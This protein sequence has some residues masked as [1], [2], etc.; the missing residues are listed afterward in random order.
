VTGGTYVVNSAGDLGGNNVIVDNS[1]NLSAILQVNNAATLSNGITLN[2]GGAL[3]NSGTIGRGGPGV[4]GDIGNVINRTGGSITSTG[5]NG[6][7]FFLGGAITNNAGAA[8]SGTTGVYSDWPSSRTATVTNSGT[9][10]GTTGNGIDLENG[11]T[12]VNQAGGRISGV[13][14]GALLWGGSVLNTGSGSII[15]ASQAGSAG[16]SLQDSGMVTNTNGA[17]IAGYDGVQ[18]WNV[19][20]LINSGGASITGN[21]GNG[22]WS[23]GGPGTVLN[24]GTGS[25]IS[26]WWGVYLDSGG[27]VTNENGA[28]ITSTGNAAVYLSD[29]GTVINGAGSSIVGNVNAVYGIYGSGNSTTVR[30]AGSITGDVR[31]DDNW[32]NRVTLFTG[33]K[34]NGDLY[35]NTDHGST[36]T[37]DGSG[38]QLYSQAVSGL[39]TFVGGVLTKQGSG[40]WI[41][42]KDVNIFTPAISP[43]STIISAGTLEVD[44]TLP[45]TVT[46]QNGGTLAGT[47]KVRATTVQ[48]GGT[49]APGRDGIGTLNVNGSYRQN[50]GSVYTVQLDPASSAADRIAVTGSV[51]LS[52][53]A[54]LNISR[55]S[56]VPYLIGTR[57]TVLTATGNISGSYTLTGNAS[58]F[59]DLVASY[60][61]HNAYLDAV[62]NRSLMQASVT[63]T[64]FAVANSIQSLPASNPLFVA[65]VNLPTDAA[66]RNAFDQLSGSLHASITGA[67]LDDSRFVR[68]AAL[69][70]LGDTSSI[71]VPSSSGGADKR[72]PQANAACTPG[73]G[74]VTTWGSTFGSWGRNNGTAATASL[75][76]SIGGFFAGADMPVADTWRLGVLTGY[77]QS[78][79]NA[80]S[81]SGSSNNY[82]LGL[83][84]GTLR[85]N[86]AMRF[87]GAYT[88]NDV[89]TNRIVA[90]P[91]FSDRLKAD[92]D[93]ATTQVF[94]E[95]GHRLPVMG[96]TIEP[97]ANA[98]YVNVRTGEFAEAGGLAALTGR[99]GNTGV[100]FTTLGVHGSTDFS[101]GSL[102]MSARET[103]GWRHA[104]GE[105]KPT[106]AVSFA[107]GSAFDVSGIPIRQDA[108]VL[109]VSLGLKLGRAIT[110]AATYGSQF[111]SSTVDQSAK[112]NFS[113]KF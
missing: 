29:G 70:R 72:K 62:Q 57:Y 68:G 41:I 112:A 79:F 103:L 86:L 91:G 45:G 60:D 109:D 35:V 77:S 49:I 69:D 94:G 58:A 16:V 53:G 81:G 71:A 46:V 98:A 1:A 59:L 43:G 63:R 76:R 90:F 24:T 66:A 17:Q 28:R 14:F 88:W 47:G 44:A 97:F 101:F 20:S 5:D 11:G 102:Q 39:T 54:I 95:L 96:A 111:S 15:S 32:S 93:S 52:G 9:I 37:L 85:G 100:A 105:V 25:T 13:S 30:N 26:G 89:T 27:T 104:F 78:H 84:G 22:V 75:D 2:N 7:Y 110:L 87:G 92:Y 3:D 82:H 80:V 83:Y 38:R 74:H 18:I 55:T 19:G 21:G 42:D 48:H 65:A 113:V 36:L 33:S 34:I 56:A 6:V 12:I 23:S 64:Q 50:A 4:T 106:S 107:G 61:A 73:A 99:H 108:V 10:T 8:I 67:L 31:L 40:T 51:T